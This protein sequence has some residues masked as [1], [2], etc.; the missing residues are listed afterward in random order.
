MKPIV[1]ALAALA[2]AATCCSPTPESS[3]TN[4][5]WLRSCA[6]SD[7]CGSASRCACGLCTRECT[8][9]DECAPGICGSSL[10]TAVKCAGGQEQ[11]VC[12]P[13]PRAPS[14]CSEFPIA[15]DT[16]LAP[17]AVAPCN[18]PGALLC[19]A[20]DAALPAEDATWYSGVMDASIEDCVV[21]EGA[22]AIRYRTQSFGYSQ[23]RMRLAS[24]VSGGLLAARFYAYVPAWVTIP[25]YLAMF[26][27]WSEDASSNGK[28]S[29]EAKPND[30]LEVYLTPNDA[31]YSSPAG[32]L[33]RD[34]WLCLTLTLDV[35]AAGGSVSLAV[36]G[37]EV[38]AQSD[39]V[40]LPNNPISVAVVEGLP[41]ADAT[42][43]EL[44]LDD[45]VVATE[46]LSCP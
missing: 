5:N 32:V 12:L 4:T 27:L 2:F 3:G 11:T 37:A 15:T 43:V 29:V 28:I 20:F 34:R 21:H 1:V 8:S 24:P 19:E 26:E 6:S 10:A 30:V 7:E 18:V 39:V 9:D 36:D 14:A 41:S 40:T 44:A 22:G 13:G 46:P 45:L 16:D 25:D 17:A 38:I 33:L 31:A 35:A 23:T 42:G